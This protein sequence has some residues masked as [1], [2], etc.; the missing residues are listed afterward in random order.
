MVWQAGFQST[1]INCNTIVGTSLRKMFIPIV[2]KIK[3]DYQSDSRVEVEF[4][5][6]AE[7][8]RLAQAGQLDNR[9]KFIDSQY[10]SAPVKFPIGTAGLKNPILEDQQFHISMM[11]SSAFE[12]DSQIENVEGVEL[13]YPI[14]WNIK[15]EC[16]PKGKVDKT[17]G[18]VTWDAQIG[19]A[20]TFVC[21]FDSLN[22]NPNAM[23][24]APSKT[25]I[26][27]AHANYTFSRWKYKDTKIEF[28][29]FCCPDT[30]GCTKDCPSEDC[31]KDQQYCINNACVYKQAEDG[32]TK[33]DFERLN[34]YCD[35]RLTYT[36]NKERGWKCLLGMGGCDGNDDCMPVTL[37][38][39]ILPHAWLDD[40][41]ASAILNPMECVPIRDGI[42]ACCYI[43]S[44]PEACKQAFEEWNR[45]TKAKPELL[46]APYKY[47]DEK[48][49]HAVYE[50]YK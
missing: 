27:T 48:A 11:L 36:E 45:Q 28:G 39:N 50:T 32:G 42:S 43:D 24:G 7:W 47:P 5:S 13:R 23:G 30:I 18:L 33:T 37:L 15:G 40:Q 31:L 3:Y 14:E 16:T 10:S 35:N 22:S 46:S 8:E 20:K 26:V 1:G 49:I 9:F 25:Y 4:I 21:Y 38:S 19:G 17:K 34:R 44:K 12:R 6:K 2:A 29:G 41:K